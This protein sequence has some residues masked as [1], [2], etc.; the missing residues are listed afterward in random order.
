MLV[1]RSGIHKILFRIANREDPDQLK[2]QSGLRLRYLSRPFLQS[3]RVQKSTCVVFSIVM[4][5][6]D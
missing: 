1:F 5:S 3:T 2:K 6:I 4:L